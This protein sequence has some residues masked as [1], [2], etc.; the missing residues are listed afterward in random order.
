MILAK[1][2]NLPPVTTTEILAPYMVVF[3]VAF[4]VAIIATP[5][6][7]LF[8][9]HSG[10]VDWPDL[11]R[12]SHIEPVAYLGGIAICLAWT[13]GICLSYFLKPDVDLPIS[14]V[15]G[16]L[17]ITFIGMIDDVYGISP[18]VKIG[19]QL[20]AAAMLASQKVGIN[21]VEQSFNIAGIP[22]HPFVIYILGTTV[23]AIFVIGGC[24]SVN[25]LDGL[26]GLASGIVAIACFG[27]LFIAVT[28]APSLQ[29]SAEGGSSFYPI[30]I[31][32]CLAILG[33]ILGFLP[34]NFNPA[35]IFMGDAGSMLLGYL[36][37]STILLF[38]E[39][40]PNGPRL[41][42]AALI[43]FAL[44]IIDTA[45]TLFRRTMRG[46]P[47]FSPDNE[48]VHHQILAATRRNLKLGP[49]LSVKFSVA[50]MYLL[51]GLF[52]YLGY[53]LVSERWRFV[54][55]FF[56]VIFGF[57]MVTAYKVGHHQVLLQKLRQAGP[58]GPQQAT[59]TITSLQDD[60]AL[61][62]DTQAADTAD[63]PETP[64]HESV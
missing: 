31:V 7:R 50:A 32:M 27:F 40:G 58:L 60:P 34:Y 30:L 10:I 24:N 6:M 29:L 41:V 4:V 26:D 38:A 2:N 25:L 3:F 61:A 1:I 45:L 43:V 42:T 20:M 8:A 36:S 23:I 16:A 5:A 21:L 52:A 48:H 11:K 63:S 35:N 17:I 12:K 47:L 64:D 39:A 62:R 57:V 37:V 55:A 18:R 49:N 59:P 28:I 14:I 15:S 13:A 54:V 51:A 53:A 22:T 19:G 44:P 56:V 33:A 46:Q 9:I